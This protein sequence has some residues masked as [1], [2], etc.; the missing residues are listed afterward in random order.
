MSRTGSKKKRPSMLANVT[1]RLQKEAEQEQK[2]QG[3]TD[4]TEEISSEKIG[5]TTNTPEKKEVIHSATDDQA[6]IEDVSFSSIAIP[7]KRADSIEEISTK[8][9]HAEETGYTGNTIEKE[10]ETDASEEISTKENSAEETNHTINPP[11]KG[12]NEKKTQSPQAQY[13]TPTPPQT[14][15]AGTTPASL[16]FSIPNQMKSPKKH[17]KGFYL[18]DLALANLRSYSKKNGISENALINFLLESLEE[19]N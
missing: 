13:P 1:A 9:N 5:Q 12:G 18:T 10:N 16:T 4:A 17:R 6:N 14:S 7:K 8:E 3:E 2:E 19:N 11:E 15:Q